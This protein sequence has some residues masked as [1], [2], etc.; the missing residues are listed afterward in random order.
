MALQAG[1]VLTVRCITANY[2]IL[3]VYYV[4]GLNHFQWT[5]ILQQFVCNHGNIHG[6]SPST[7]SCNFFIALYMLYKVN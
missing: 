5:G 4:Y 1:S 7:G 6:N 2:S 3:Y